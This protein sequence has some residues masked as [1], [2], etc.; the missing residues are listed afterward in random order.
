MQGAGLTDDDD[1]DD[2]AEP[3][4]PTPRSD[5]VETLDYNRQV[6]L[7]C[8]C[9]EEQEEEDPEHDDIVD[10]DSDSDEMRE[11]WPDCSICGIAD[12]H[13]IDFKDGNDYICIDCRN[14]ILAARGEPELEPEPESACDVEL[15]GPDV[16]LEPACDAELAEHDAGHEQVAKRR[17]L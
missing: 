5:S 7:D 13:T 2:D 16:E 11:R 17:R 12:E 10:D 3:I 8:G 6:V 1:D 15:A 4:E 14:V 9:D